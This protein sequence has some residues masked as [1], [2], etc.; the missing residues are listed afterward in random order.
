MEEDWKARTNGITPDL[1]L[2]FGDGV[3]AMWPDVWQAGVAAIAAG[4]SSY[5]DSGKEKAD[6]FR[7][8]GAEFQRALQQKLIAA[9]DEAVVEQPR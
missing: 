7:K 4:F 5:D 1:G 2:Y 6:T 3:V 9:R 8:K